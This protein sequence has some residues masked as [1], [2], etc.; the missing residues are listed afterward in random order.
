[1]P[2]SKKASSPD[3]KNPVGEALA[4]AL[5][6][7]FIAG[8]LYLILGGVRWILLLPFDRN[9]TFASVLKWIQLVMALIMLGVGFS[10]SILKFFRVRRAVQ[11]SEANQRVAAALNE[12]RQ[13]RPQQN[14]SDISAADVAKSLTDAKVNQVQLERLVEQGKQQI[15]ID[16]Y[17]QKE[18]GSLIVTFLQPLPRNA[19]RLVNRFKVNLLI[20]HNRGLLSSEPRVTAQQIGKWLV[21]MER[22]PQLGRSLSAAPEKMGML[23]T[24]AD[25]SVT[26]KPDGSDQDLFM[27][28]IKLLSPPYVNDEDLRKF[29]W[30]TPRLGQIAE[31]LAHYGAGELSTSAAGKS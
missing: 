31:R 22:W 24:E 7:V 11:A 2:E 4:M 20:A 25:E 5:G 23:E 16:E 19:K 21:L 14:V 26:S 10:E 6:A 29:I 13:Q 27:E 9:G 18:L 17:F 12:I 30:S 15:L 8:L 3:T 1:M 28:S